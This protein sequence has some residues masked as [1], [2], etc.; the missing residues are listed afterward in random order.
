MSEAS[1]GTVKQVRDAKSFFS[2]LASAKQRQAA[3]NLLPGDQEK[4]SA[5]FLGA[6]PILTHGMEDS[7]PRP[8]PLLLGAWPWVLSS[9]VS[10]C[11]P[12]AFRPI[13]S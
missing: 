9:G 4:A 2:S 13:F 5:D 1:T 3:C 8:A 11:C 7:G 10:W 6:S 12:D